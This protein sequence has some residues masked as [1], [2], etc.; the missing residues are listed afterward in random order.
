LLFGGCS[1]ASHQPQE[2]RFADLFI[3]FGCRNHARILLFCGSFLT[4][5]NSQSAVAVS[6]RKH[7]HPFVKKS[8]L[9]LEHLTLFFLTWGVL[10]EYIMDA[11]FLGRSQAALE[12][13]CSI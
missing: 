7:R 11:H 5:C 4:C 12:V 13:T 9:P 2:E 10:L 1:T 6:D 3:L 8:F